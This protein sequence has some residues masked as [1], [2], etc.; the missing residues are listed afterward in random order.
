MEQFYDILKQL[1]RTP[2]VVGA[3][4]YDALLA[5]KRSDPKSGY[6]S[7]HADRH[8]LIFIR[9]RKSTTLNK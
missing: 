1:I 8:G 9:I 3:E 4:H 2:S 5:A 6:I 7:V